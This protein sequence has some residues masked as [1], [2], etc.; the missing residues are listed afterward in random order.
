MRAGPTTPRSPC[1]A[2]RDGA[3]FVAYDGPVRG[4]VR[5]EYHV[6]GLRL[7]RRTP[8]KVELDEAVTF[9]E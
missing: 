2:Q 3:D 8:T 5:I 4:G 9:S 1:P 6:N 7:I